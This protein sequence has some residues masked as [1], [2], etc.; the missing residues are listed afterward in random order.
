MAN[1]L[2]KIFHPTSIA[3]IGASDK[4][5]TV[6]NALIKNLL[7]GTYTGKVYAVNHKHKT[8]QGKKSYPSIGSIKE[9]VDLA[10]IATPAKTVP[11]LVKECGEAGVKG[12]VIISAGF[13][14]S[15]AEGQAMYDD[16]LQLA[17]HYH[18]RIIGPNCLGFIHPSIGLNA[19]FTN[20]MALPGNIAFISQSGALCTAI[21]DWSIAE[22]VG[23]SHF[24][25][26]GSMLDVGFHDLIDYFGTDAHTSSILIYMESLQN[27]RRFMSAARAFARY[28]PIIVLKAGKSE[29]GA[30][31]SLSHTGSLAGN[32][33]IY[34]AA[35]R[36]AGIIEVSTIQQLFNCAKALAI[37]P[38]PK[39][40]RLGIV[41]NA[42]GP[43]ILATDYLIDNGGQL[44]QLRDETKAQLDA[45][46][47][48]HWSHGNPVDVLGD[49]SADT[50]ANAVQLCASDP[51][52][53]AVLAIF[54]TQAVTSPTAA[55]Q[56]LVEKQL[57]KP[58]LACWMGEE[59]VSEGREV[60]EKGRIP[61]YRYPESAV[62]VFLKMYG[63]SRNLQ[64][65]HETPPDIPEKFNPD[66]DAA[67]ELIQQVLSDG[68]IQMT[69]SEAKALLNCYEI[70][71]P[72]G[73]IVRSEAE[74]RAYAQ[75]IGF[76]VVMKVAS[77]DIGHKS[78]FGGVV[79]GIKTSEEAAAAF[80]SIRINA[81]K[82]H[83]EAKILGVRLEQMVS[84]TYE[85]LVGAKKDPV[86]GPA[87]LF[88]SG[89]V[90][91]EWLKDTCI[92][93]PPLNMALAKR[94]IEG[95]RVYRLLQGYRGRAAVDMEALQFLLVKFSYLLMDFPEI[96][97]IDINPFSV[98]EK[99]GLA[100]DAHIVLDNPWLYAKFHPYGHLVISPYPT[101]LQR[102]FTMK[103][104]QKALLRPIRPE[105]EPIEAAMLDNLSSQ[106][107]YYRFMGYV[108]KMTHETLFRFTQIDYDREMAIVAI[109]EEEGV[110]KMAGVVRII[111]D[112]W[113]EAAEY[114]ILV[115][116]PWQKQGLGG[117]LTDFILDI[118]RERKTGKVYAD[119]LN[120]NEGMLALLRKHHFVITQREFDATSLEIE[121]SP[122]TV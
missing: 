47:P 51:G 56:A 43:G 117:A 24:V 32:D 84:K 21:L 82:H 119:V 96:R 33:A 37:Q 12:L 59:A 13:K 72:Q 31:A 90:L 65:L 77:P 18:M 54:T 114:A 62:V 23:F 113:N 64:L 19:S 66:R 4:E 30:K 40:N 98:D 14:E 5:G 104:G 71:T 102:T 35:F 61:N 78:D 68:R 73:K 93:L 83:P 6:G 108:P 28:K 67:S 103:N 11:A 79:V 112:P 87:I 120:S 69:E 81:K 86:F 118:A 10:I 99:G 16:I 22:N 121:L 36:R 70:P 58:V 100:L 101:H 27:P 97:E 46:L 74:A 106:S 20:G 29:E 92:G 49:A 75:E 89:G 115:A 38:L 26:I 53:D 63:Y 110:Q 34:D 111:S 107:L 57:T 44:A 7:S 1:P 52:V 91:V 60:L 3:A 39:S 55:A 8:I 94:V 42:G 48:A 41:T 17:R 80:T 122:L 88:G 105:D 15:G 95:T 76:P 9:S 85:L 25:S 116:D 109:L 45:Q 50:F 2:K